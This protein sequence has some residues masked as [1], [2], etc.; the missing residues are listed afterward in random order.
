MRSVSKRREYSTPSTRYLRVI[1]VLATVVRV[2]ELLRLLLRL[3]L[4]SL[5]VKEVLALGLGEL[6]DLS[7][8]EARNELLGELVRDW[9]S[10]VTKQS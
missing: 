4:G 2:V 1:L 8:G 3:V 5:A 6:V 9:L 10:C 7:T